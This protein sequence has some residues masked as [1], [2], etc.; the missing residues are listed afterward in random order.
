MTTWMPDAEPV[1]LQEI[2]GQEHVKRALEVS[3]AGGHHILLTGAPDADKTRLAQALVGLLPPWSPA[4]AA[5]VATMTASADPAE[6]SMPDFSQR[7]YIVAHPDVSK[8]ALYGGG[9]G[10]A[11]PGAVSQAH[12]G[13]LLLD[14][15]PAFGALLI[16]LAAILDDR[17]VTLVRASGTITLPAAF[18]LVGTARPCACGWSGDREH[19]CTCAPAALRRYQRQLPDALRERIAIHVTVPRV[20]DAQLNTGRLSEPSAVVRARV[21]A[22]CQHQAER[23]ADDPTCA[24]NAE[25]G[26]AEIRVH[27]VLD[28]AGQSLIQAAVRQL[29]LSAGAYHRTLRLARTIADLAG[30]ERIGAAHIAEALQYRASQTC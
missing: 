6:V 7:P 28:S 8:A 29:A 21:M 23:F 27:C 25:M 17:S 5:A 12:R 15:L 20:V 16:P 1:D 14:D 13:V 18:Q 30:A 22:A 24:T 10:R 3:A 2:P 9:A 4:E 11:R 19:P 26:L